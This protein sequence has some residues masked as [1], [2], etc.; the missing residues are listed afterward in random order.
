MCLSSSLKTALI[1]Q[2]WFGVNDFSFDGDGH[3]QNVSRS[4]RSLVLES[5][6]LPSLNLCLS[7]LSRI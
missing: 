5:Y 6:K 3:A 2:G 4:G 7:S 1:S